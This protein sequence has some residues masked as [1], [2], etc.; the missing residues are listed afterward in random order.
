MRVGHMGVLFRYLTVGAGS[1]L[2]MLGLAGWHDHLAA[3]DFRVADTQGERYPTVQALFYMAKL[4]A[5][6]TSRHHL[7]VF[8]SRQ[9]GEEK[10]TVEQTR[11]GAIDLNRV[12][13]A[14]LASFAPEASVLALPFLSPRRITSTACST[15]RSAPISWPSSS[16]R[17]RRSHL[18]RRRRALDLQ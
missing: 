17:L 11:A 13:V 6:R 14:P 15:G 9:L 5:G 8:H 1:A 12:S 10:E 4:V 16:P 7:I 18:L 2:A 3:R